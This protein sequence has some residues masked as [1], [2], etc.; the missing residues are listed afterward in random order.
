MS[1]HLISQNPEAEYGLELFN[2]SEIDRHLSSNAAE[3][4][5]SLQSDMTILASLLFAQDLVIS[6]VTA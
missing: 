4:P 6:L 3:V 5:I 2:H 1:Y